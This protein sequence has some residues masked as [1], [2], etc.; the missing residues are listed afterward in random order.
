M[1]GES[2]AEGGEGVNENEVNH[3][4]P[5]MRALINLP[6]SISAFVEIIRKRCADSNAAQPC[7]SRRDLFFNL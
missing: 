6:R 7:I 5:E 3:L 4:H 2:I 1:D